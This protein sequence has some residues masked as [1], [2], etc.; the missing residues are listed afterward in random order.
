TGSTKENIHVE[1]CSKCHPF[2]TGQQ[3]ANKA[4]GRIEQFNKKYGFDNK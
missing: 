2:Y 1:V 4:R 3:K